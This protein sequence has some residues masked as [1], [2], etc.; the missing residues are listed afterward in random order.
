M[1][2]DI[3]GVAYRHLEPTCVTL[4]DFTDF[5]ACFT[6]MQHALAIKPGAYAA[7]SVS[8]FDE[9]PM[10]DRTIVIRFGYSGTPG[11]LAVTLIDQDLEEVINDHLMIFLKDDQKITGRHMEGGADDESLD[12]IVKIICDYGFYIIQALQWSAFLFRETGEGTLKDYFDNQIYQEI[13]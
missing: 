6:L 13:H 2:Y 4:T 5:S 10:K 7:V 12:E 8:L 3:L 9:D 1:D 11:K